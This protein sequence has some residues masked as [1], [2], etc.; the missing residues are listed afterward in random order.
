MEEPFLEPRDAFFLRAFKELS[1]CRQ[2][3]MGPGPIPWDKIIAYGERAG[4]DEEMLEAF[5]LI[6]RQMDGAYLEWQEEE[7]DKKERAAK[8]KK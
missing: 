5:V 4:L 2:I 6:M 1:T 3:G 7:R 8:A